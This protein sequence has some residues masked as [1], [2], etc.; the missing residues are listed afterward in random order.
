MAVD[1]SKYL[2]GKGLKKLIGLIADLFPGGVLSVAKGGTGNNTGTATKIATTADTS[3]TL[4]VTGVTSGATTTLKRDTSVSVKGGTVTATTFSGNATSATKA[5]QD[6]SGNVIENTYAASLT[7]SGNDLQLVNKKNGSIGSSVKIA[8]TDTN[9][10]Y[11]FAGGTNGFTVTPSGSSA[12]TV[13]VTP[14][15]TNNVTGS[16]TS[17]YIAKFNGK[18][19]I[20]NG[21]AF[22]SGTTKF[23][24]E[25]GSWATVASS[26]TTYTFATGSD[27]GTFKVTPSGGT[28]QSVAIKGLAALAYKASLT[29]SDIPD[30]S[31][32]KIT[33]GT[34]A[35]ARGGTGQT[36]VAN[37]KAG[38]DADGNTISTTYVKIGG[39][40]SAT[41]LA[42]NVVRNVTISKNAPTSSDGAI[43]DIWIQYS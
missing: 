1:E 13:S 25:D 20:T 18:N 23:L 9:T 43:G 33:T 27:N 7:L 11:T 16:G 2:N 42:S 10:T 29:A 26:D 21:P 3:N 5:S 35:V 28:A 37:I 41:T 36:S 39:A 8:T 17:G 6:G 34:L 30:L 31:A 22:G 19:T 14:S 24:R 12:L 4:Y 40:T 38:K 32:S 15:I